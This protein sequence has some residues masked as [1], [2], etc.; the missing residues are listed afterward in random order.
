[1]IHH[2]AMAKLK[3]VLNHVHTEEELRALESGIDAI[4]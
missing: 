1:M 4:M 3:T 2:Q